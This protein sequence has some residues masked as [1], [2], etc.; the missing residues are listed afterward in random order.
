ML[1]S[2]RLFQIVPKPQDNNYSRNPNFLFFSLSHDSSYPDTC[3]ASIQLNSHRNV[4]APSPG[5]HS[6]G[7]A[8][9]CWIK[10]VH[11]NRVSVSISSEVLWEKIELLICY[12]HKAIYMHRKE[13]KTIQRFLIKCCEIKLEP[14]E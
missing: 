5:H 6:D 1:V 11:N 14:K 10:R 9:E 4:R 12:T 3:E 2:I 7:T 13:A 8:F